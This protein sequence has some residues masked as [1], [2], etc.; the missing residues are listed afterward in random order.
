MQSRLDALEEL[1]RNL[2]AQMQRPG[3]DAQSD[4]PTRGPGTATIRLKDTS[5][6]NL[7]DAGLL[8]V[9]YLSKNLPIYDFEP[10]RVWY[11]K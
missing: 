1:V 4:I 11:T 10:K 5:S 7:H 8:A 3:T 9:A 2:Q 6:T